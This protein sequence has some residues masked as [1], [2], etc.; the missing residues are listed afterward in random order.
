ME[1]RVGFGVVWPRETFPYV[2]YWQMFGGGVGYPWYG[3]TYNL[4]L[5]PFTSIPNQGI[6]FALES[7]TALMLQPREE[8]TNWIKALAHTAGSPI[9]HIDNAGT[10]T[11]GE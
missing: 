5:E 9:K 10:I 8:R 6:E 4:G 11:A 7:N 3:R 2:W 1:R